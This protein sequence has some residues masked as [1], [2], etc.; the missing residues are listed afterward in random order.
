MP[1]QHVKK[2]HPAGAARNQRPKERNRIQ[3]P[4][5]RPKKGGFF[6]ALKSLFRP[7]FRKDAPETAQESLPFKT[8]YRDGICKVNEKLYTKTIQFHDIN[9][10]LSQNEDKTQIFESYC[11]FLNYFDATINVQ[12]TFINKQINLEDFQKNIEIPE[13]DDAYNEIRREYSEMLKNQLAK[14]NNGLGATRS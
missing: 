1:K 7:L 6:S 13:C 12:L 2:K 10:Q 3:K 14:G 4:T 8:M 5:N 9:Y 11:E